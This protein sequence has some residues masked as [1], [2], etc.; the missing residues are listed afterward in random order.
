M[1][2]ALPMYF[3]GVCS[4]YSPGSVRHFLGVQNNYGGPIFAKLL[5]DQVVA[6]VP[7]IRELRPES[8]TRGVTTT[9][10]TTALA[11]AEMQSQLDS[12]TLRVAHFINTR[13]EA[14]Q[15]LGEQLKLI[16]DKTRGVKL[17]EVFL[18]TLHASKFI[19]PQVDESI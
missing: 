19:A 8:D 3:R 18:M 6:M 12:D 2:H 1:K 7:D 9:K 5:H 16:S 10:H 15:E 4:R 11:I 17:A 14:L 13:S